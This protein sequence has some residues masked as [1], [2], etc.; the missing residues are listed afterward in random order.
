ME[1]AKKKEPAPPTTGLIVVGLMR[2]NRRSRL[3]GDFDASTRCKMGASVASALVDGKY[4]RNTGWG[5]GA[6]QTRRRSRVP[7]NALDRIGK[8]SPVIGWHKDPGLSVLKDIDDAGDFVADDWNPSGMAS[9]RTSP[10]PSYLEGKTNRS[11][12]S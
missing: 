3:A 6:C 7:Q 10:W 4:G 12:P 9:A 5:R 11:S 1:L 2:R 8:G